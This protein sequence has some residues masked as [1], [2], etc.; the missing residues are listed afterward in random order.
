MK[1]LF[2]SLIISLI[3]LNCASLMPLANSGYIVTKDN[4]KIEFQNARL[5]DDGNL[6][7]INS[8]YS[9]HNFMK[10]DIKELHLN[11]NDKDYV[12]NR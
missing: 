10:R 1:K 7:I 6:I 11:F 3:F 8:K 5:W 12:F 9:I 4:Q 2:L